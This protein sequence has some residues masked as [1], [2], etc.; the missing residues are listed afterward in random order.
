[1]TDV[2]KREYYTEAYSIIMAYGPE[3]INKI[4][5]KIW[6]NIKSMILPDYSFHYNPELSFK[7]QNV[8]KEAVALLTAFKLQYWS[9]DEEKE[10][11][12]G[13]IRTN[14][15]KHEQEKIEKYS[16]DKMFQNT[17]TA[18]MHQL[19]EENAT[20]DTKDETQVTDLQVYQENVILKII[21]KIKELIKNI[22]KRR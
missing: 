13:T 12:K 15:E 7:K 2:Y 4:P 16:Y 20:V 9:N 3:Y 14:K 21:H 8:K 17:G 5:Q 10:R 19:E 1:M 22:F 6:E 11:I 18:V